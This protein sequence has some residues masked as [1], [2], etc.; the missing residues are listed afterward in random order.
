MTKKELYILFTENSNITLNCDYCKI[1][2]TYLL[3]NKCYVH[4]NITYLW[5]IIFGEL[6]SFLYVDAFFVFLSCEF[7]VILQ[8]YL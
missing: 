5:K 8:K 7:F 1:L 3:K 4:K 6:L 2:K